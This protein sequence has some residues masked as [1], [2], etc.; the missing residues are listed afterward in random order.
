MEPHDVQGADTSASKDVVE[1]IKSRRI[2]GKLIDR[3]LA[4]RRRNG[5]F[6]MSDGRR[7]CE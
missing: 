3:I 1:E 6:A 5:S 7:Y 2:D 4:E